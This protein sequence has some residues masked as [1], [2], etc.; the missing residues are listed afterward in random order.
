MAV[1]L[2]R[3]GTLFKAFGAVA[4]DSEWPRNNLATQA[5]APLIGVDHPEPEPMPAI[6]GGPG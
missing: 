4:E 5:L 6:L 1:H 2:Q 3:M